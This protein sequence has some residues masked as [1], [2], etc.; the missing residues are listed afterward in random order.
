MSVYATDFSEYTVGAQ[1][2]DWTLR[3]A[4]DFSWQVQADATG[5][6]GKILKA[7]AGAANSRNGLSWDVVDGDPDVVDAQVFYRIRYPSGPANGS[8]ELLAMTRGKGTTSATAYRHG[9]RDDEF[10][11]SR[12]LN[13]NYT[14]FGNTFSSAPRDVWLNVLVTVRG[15]THTV[16]SWPDGDPEPGTPQLTETNSDITLEGWVG[17][18]KFLA[19]EVDIDYVGVGTGLDDAPRPGSGGVLL[20]NPAGLADGETDYTGSVGVDVDNGTLYHVVTTSVTK[21]T[22]TQI[23]SGQD[24]NGVA[25][26]ASGSQTVSSA[27]TKQVSGTGLFGGTTYYIHYQHSAAEGESLV[28]TSAGFTTAAP[29]PPTVAVPV[30]LTATQVTSTSALLGW[31]KG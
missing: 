12:Y 28:V 29:P 30:N 21:P 15:T 10:L 4:A 20:T 18:F 5:T 26:P 3:F 1:P 6:G 13:G 7:I 22:R 19:G 17:L 16:K 11:L 24:D 25:A 8:S 31:E 2:S 23:Q 14:G 9:R 27:G